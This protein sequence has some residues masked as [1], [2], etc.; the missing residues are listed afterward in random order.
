MKTI[1]KIYSSL[2]ETLGKSQDEILLRDYLE[3]PLEKNLIAIHPFPHIV[4][5]NLLKK[6]AY[7]K[8][9]ENFQMVMSRG[10]STNERDGSKFHY[11]DI[12][13]DGYLF[14]PSPSLEESNPLR[15]FYSMEWQSTISRLFCQ[16]ITYETAVAYHHHPSG[17]ETGFV[18]HD[19]SF[20]FFDRRT[21]LKNFVIPKS[22][23]D[24]DDNSPTL[25]KRRRAIAIIL[26]VNNGTWIE[27]D[28]GETGLYLEDKITCVKRVAPID[29]RILIFQISEKS[30]HAF[31]K[32]LKERNCIVQWFHTIDE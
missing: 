24:S 10:L 6:E 26:Y 9:V 28:G 8:I 14:T 18:H 2:I 4:V 13:Y 1:E 30:M 32:N 20:K 15:L 31:Q 7:Q 12:D 16:K 29:N 25:L 19:F 3:T 17:D 23:R 11:F 21:R 27:G 22:T 5:D